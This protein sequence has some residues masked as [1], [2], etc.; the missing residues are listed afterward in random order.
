MAES[1]KISPTTGRTSHFWSLDFSFITP[2]HYLPFNYSTL[3]LKSQEV[4]HNFDDGPTCD[5]IKVHMKKVF[6]FL[7]IFVGVL[8]LAAVPTEVVFA[9]APDTTEASA[10]SWCSGRNGAEWEEKSEKK[11]VCK[12]IKDTDK[13]RESCTKDAHGEINDPKEG[14][15]KFQCVWNGKFSSG[16]STTTSTQDV[17]GTAGSSSAAE[18]GKGFLG[19]SPWYKGVTTIVN[20][21]CEVATPSSVD[22]GLTKFVITIVLNILAD[23]SLAVGYL[24]LGFIIYGGFLYIMAGGD[25]GKVAKGKKTLTAAVIGTA[26]AMLST[27]I[28]NLIVGALTGGG[29]S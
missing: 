12:G 19:F 24:A 22:G 20:G 11:H 5:K 7:A 1:A 4:E 9:G 2:N 21:R 29:G 16:E 18:C 23:L 3:K 14:D 10:K 27:V 8:S 26:I 15:K 25:P 6:V 17:G 13:N 28:L